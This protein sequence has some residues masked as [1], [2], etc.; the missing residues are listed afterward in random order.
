[1]VITIIVTNAGRAAL[2]NAANTGTNAVT[3]TQLG[4]TATA[5]AA[6]P[7]QVAL[8]GEIKR[9][10]SVA[11]VVVADDAIHVTA[12]DVTTDA[13]TMRGFAL[14]LA[15]GTLFAL[16]GQAGAILNKTAES[17]ML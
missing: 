1:M 5:F 13:Y 9:I 10:A 15:D 14:Y 6:D 2:V 8:P 11:G 4:I 7:A 3:I 12:S 16:Y 17:M